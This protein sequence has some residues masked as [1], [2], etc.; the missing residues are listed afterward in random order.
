M[1]FLHIS[2]THLGYSQY[3]LEE[4]KKDFLDVFYEAV[5]KAI[6]EKVDFVIHSGD[7]FHTSRPS[8]QTF[9][10]G[11]EVVKK[12]K[13]SNIPIF[14]ISGNHDRGS[15]V[16]DVSPLAILEPIGLNLVDGGFKEF[17]GIYIGGLKYISKAGLKQTGGI[18]V[19]LEK[20]LESLNKEGFKILMLHQEFAP[21]F[22]NSDLYMEKEIP[23]GFD[24][25]GIGHYHVKQEPKYINSATVVYPGSTEFT[26]YNEN[27]DKVEKGFYIVE[28]SSKIKCKFYSFTKKRPFLSL[29]VDEENIEAQIKEL[30]NKVETIL[31]TGKKKPV[32]IFK[33]VLKNLDLVDITKLLEKEGLS[34][35]KVLHY[36]FNLTKEAKIIEAKVDSIENEDILKALKDL[37]EDEEIFNIVE[38]AVKTLQTF[39]NTDEMKKFLKEHPEILDLP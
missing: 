38:E 34:E 18:R 27:E 37:L 15:Q 14:T 22:P 19:I 28:V 33:G 26:A 31:D 4:R 23:E 39:E 2:D 24:Y 10:E 12:L 29:V 13:E 1:K 7:F 16:R 30:K 3:G 36:R 35:N 11:L 8:N 21:L 6:E 32:V 25:I 5:D 9:L 17:N 20:Y